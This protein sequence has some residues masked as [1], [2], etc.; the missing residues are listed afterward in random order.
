MPSPADARYT[1]KQTHLPKHKRVHLDISEGVQETMFD[2]AVLLGDEISSRFE[3]SP[4]RSPYKSSAS[5]SGDSNHSAMSSAEK[6]SGLN[7]MSAGELSLSSP[8]SSQQQIKLRFEQGM[9]ELPPSSSYAPLSLPLMKST[10]LPPKPQ[11]GAISAKKLLL[12]TAKMLPFSS[13]ALLS[14][15]KQPTT[16][17]PNMDIKGHCNCK[18]SKCLKL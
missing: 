14:K 2:D 7:I 11:E 6:I 13:P 16:L 15:P 5:P 4:E 12:S 3:P 17:S 1:L 10:P 8:L 18:K 9:D